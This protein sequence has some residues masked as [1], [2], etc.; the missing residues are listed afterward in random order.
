MKCYELALT[1]FINLQLKPISYL[2][3]S[4]E[5]FQQIFVAEL[6][7]AVKLRLF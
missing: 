4:W 7:V 2:A 5:L 3:Q 1:T 6:T